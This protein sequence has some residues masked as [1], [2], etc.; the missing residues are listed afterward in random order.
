[1]MAQWALSC[2]EPSLEPLKE[3]KS[4]ECYW[5]VEFHVVQAIGYKV[6]ELHMAVVGIRF[7]SCLSHHQLFGLGGGQK[8]V[9][10][11]MR[12]IVRLTVDCTSTGWKLILEPGILW[13]WKL[14]GCA[15]MEGLCTAAIVKRMVEKVDMENRG[16][17]VKV[18]ADVSKRW[19][20]AYCRTHHS[21]LSKEKSAHIDTCWMIVW[22]DRISLKSPR[23]FED[24]LRANDIMQYLLGPG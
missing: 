7:W 6:G 5:G 1:M 13:V 20:Y 9:N 18:E 4:S 14:A 19:K 12:G 11:N 17:T 3:N 15:T 8:L 2:R 24:K 22:V 21:M 16:F 23:V 10:I